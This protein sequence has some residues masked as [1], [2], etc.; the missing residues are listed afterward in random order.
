MFKKLEVLQL[1]NHVQE[2]SDSEI[3]KDR[4]REY[5]LKS[6]A[7]VFGVASPEEISKRSPEGHSPKDFL[8]NVRSVVVIGGGK[9]LAGAMRCRDPK[10]VGVI[11][12]QK[13]RQV[14][15]ISFKLAEYIEELGYYAIP[16]AS[17]SLANGIWDPDISIKLCAELAGLGTRSLAGGI[18]LNPK[19]GFLFYS[20][21]LTSAPLKPDEPLKEPVCPHPSCVRMWERN[22]TTPCLKACPECLSGEIEN[23][24]IKWMK[25]NRLLCYPKANWSRVGFQK[26]LLDIINE[27]DPEKRKMM[28]LGSRFTSLVS[29]LAYSIVSAQCYRCTSVCPVGREFRAKR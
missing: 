23:G 7:L 1:K 4:I 2:S 14:K 9:M 21:V 17:Y 8:P 3:L 16:Y 28:I 29:A 27:S 18:V 6:G 12:S 11:G 13:L 24:R 20:I 25:Y 22:H 19:Y 26:A 10:W 15:E 5:A